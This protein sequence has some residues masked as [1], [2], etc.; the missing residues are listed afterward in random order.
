MKITNFVRTQLI[1]FSV[2]TAIAMVAMAVLYIRIPAMAGLG[3]GWV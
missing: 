1:I 2:V 3:G